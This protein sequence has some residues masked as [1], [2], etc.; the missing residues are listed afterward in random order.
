M[1]AI[2]FCLFPRT[3]N[4][5]RELNT[6]ATALRGSQ[7]LLVSRTGRRS[8]EKRVPAPGHLSSDILCKGPGCKGTM[9]T[10][11]SI[12]CCQNLTLLP[13]CTGP[14]VGGAGLGDRSLEGERRRL[15]TPGGLGARARAPLLPPPGSP[16]EGL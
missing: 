2:A 1:T 5:A 10:L 8:L 9:G 4:P 6:F 11:P 15:S 14:R 3:R 12:P 7:P 13:V 16:A